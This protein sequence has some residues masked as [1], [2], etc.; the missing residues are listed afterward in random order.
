M[1]HRLVK[2]ISSTLC[3]ILL[4]C[5]D[6]E[7]PCFSVDELWNDDDLALT[8]SDD[9]SFGSH[10]SYSQ[11]KEQDLCHS[12]YFKTTAPERCQRDSFEVK[13]ALSRRSQFIIGSQVKTPQVTSSPGA[14]GLEQPNDYTEN[15]RKISCLLSP[16]LA[17]SGVRD[18][19]IANHSGHPRRISRVLPQ[20]PNSP[21]SDDFGPTI[22]AGCARR[23]NKE[24][25]IGPT[26]DRANRSKTG[27][28]HQYDKWSSATKEFLLDEFEG[29]NWGVF[30]DNAS[31][32]QRINS[33]TNQKEYVPTNI[34]GG[35][36]STSLDLLVMQDR[37][38]ESRICL[39][40]NSV[41][42]VDV[43][44]STDGSPQR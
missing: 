5:F 43:D 38:D 24:Q 11:Q 39:K 36:S 3:F 31:R 14:D 8:L 25:W 18:P 4:D 35:I 44:F 6:D 27:T 22:R 19:G 34:R 10:V 20:P 7:L 41:P 21:G 9:A 26:E 1:I 30:P 13:Q 23:E 42:V 29:E 32:I 16:Q 40:E 2:T 33:S 37:K 15:P 28:G 17:T 12:N